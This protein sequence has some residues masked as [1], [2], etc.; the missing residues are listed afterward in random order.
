MDTFLNTDFMHH[1]LD[2]IKC[3]FMYF[4]YC[5]FLKKQY[6][7]HKFLEFVDEIFI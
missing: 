4:L 2:L 5:L 1:T 3:V 6:C 7:F